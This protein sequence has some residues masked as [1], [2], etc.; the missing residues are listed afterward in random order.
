MVERGRGD[1]M[2]V[3]WEWPKKTVEMVGED[4]VFDTC[5]TCNVVSLTKL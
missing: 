1:E 2:V 5:E 4:V 3:G